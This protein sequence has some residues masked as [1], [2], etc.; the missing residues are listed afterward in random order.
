MN[1]EKKEN[2]CSI[3]GVVIEDGLAHCN[4]CRSKYRT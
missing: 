4:N 2:T 3:C 1:N